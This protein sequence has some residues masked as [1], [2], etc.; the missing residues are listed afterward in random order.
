MLALITF[1][2]IGQTTGK[3][4]SVY[5]GDT[6]TVRTASETIK[7]RLVH[8]DAPERGQAFGTRSRQHLSELVFG[9]QVEL[10]GTERDRYGRLLA[11]VKVEGLEVN[12]EMVRS[13]MAWAY[14]EYKPPANYISTEQKARA[15]KVGLW[16]DRQP[17][18][19]WEYRKL[20]RA[21]SK[22]VA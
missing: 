9:K 22:K 14:L 21:K 10:I 3:V 16:A 4:V 12:L 11:V 17:I 6:V 1:L 15:G 2:L 13:G 5:D 19:P 20:I 18:A 7:V 8:L